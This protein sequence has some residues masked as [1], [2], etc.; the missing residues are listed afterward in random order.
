MENKE[1][2]K[3]KKIDFRLTIKEYKQI[4]Q[5]VKSSGKKRPEYILFRLLYPNKPVINSKDLFHNLNDI[6]IE[7]SK[8]GTNINQ[9]VKHMNSEMILG[10]I[11][12]TTIEAFIELLKEHNTLKENINI[13]YRNILSKIT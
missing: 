8:S 3:T 6:G 11:K 1:K 5:Q 2:I 10:Q 9:V 12:P 4:M 13:E 7:L